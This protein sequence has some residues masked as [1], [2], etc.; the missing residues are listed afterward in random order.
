MANLCC[1]SKVFEKLILKRISEL[2]VINGITVGGKQQHGFMRNKST[3]AAGL[4]LQ[5][6]IARALDNDEYG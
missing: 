2:K 6:L 5:S 4:M 1:I 3:V